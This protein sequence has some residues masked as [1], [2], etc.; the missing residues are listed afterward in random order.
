MTAPTARPELVAQL[1]R[2]GFAV[3]DDVLDDGQVAAA[4]VALDEVFASEADIASERGWLTTA[5]RVAY[6]LPVKHPLFVDLCT[7]A[8]VLALPRAVLGED[9]VIAGCNGLDVV[10]GGTAQALHRDHA[11]PTPG[12]TAYLHLVCALDPFTPERGATRVVPGSH[13]EDGVAA[14]PAAFETTATAVTV[15]PGG[16]VAFDATLLHAAGANMTGEPRRALHLF[17]ARAWARPHWDFPGTFT[18]EE[19]AALSE[20]QRARF[21]FGPGPRRF[22][23][24]A[25]RVVR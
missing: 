2:D 19:A 22:D 12:T 18:D 10:A 23:R 7:D 14:D 3:L 8:S 4:T 21:G 9:C 11:D 13:R 20:D 16:A 17:F 6:A 15:P 24:A 25:R 5:Y 1:A